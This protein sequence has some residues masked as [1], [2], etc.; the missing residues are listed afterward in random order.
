M[1]VDIYLRAWQMVRTQIISVLQYFFVLLLFLPRSNFGIQ[2][3]LIP[4]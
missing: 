3:S 2:Y 1:Y 4:E